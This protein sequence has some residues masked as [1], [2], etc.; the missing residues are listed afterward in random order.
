MSNDILTRYEKGKRKSDWSLSIK[1]MSR[2][3]KRL[4]NQASL[5][6]DERCQKIRLTSALRRLGNQTLTADVGKR[7][8]EGTRIPTAP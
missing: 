6:C 2:D 7:V 5:R 4:E 8:G 3:R 1:K